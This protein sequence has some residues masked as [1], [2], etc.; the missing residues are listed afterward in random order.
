MYKL[1]YEDDNDIEYKQIFD[2]KEQCI[3]FIKF[4][5]IAVY[6]YVLYQYKNGSMIQINIDDVLKST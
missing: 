3:A 2:T 1:K 4:W 6:P 5:N